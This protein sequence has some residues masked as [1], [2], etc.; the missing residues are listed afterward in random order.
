MTKETA[1]QIFCEHT[2]I[3]EAIDAL[4]AAGIKFDPEPPEKTAGEKIADKF[5]GSVT[6]S[7]ENLII[8]IDAAIQADRHEHK[9]SRSAVEMA[10]RFVSC[11]SNSGL[12]WLGFSEDERISLRIDGSQNL[13]ELRNGI[14]AQLA[15]AFELAKGGGAKVDWEKEGR[16][17]ISF[18]CDQATA[19]YGFAWF[20]VHD[21]IVKHFHSKAIAAK[22][23]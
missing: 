7:R 13:F 10:N 11:Y 23:P 16:E 2:N 21:R 6:S 17:L 5:F 15:S 20:A 12:L 14:S 22:Q 9:P 1:R 19:Q 4:A 3:V 18:V 8:W